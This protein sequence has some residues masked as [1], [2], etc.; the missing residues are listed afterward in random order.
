MRRSPKL[1][2][3]PYQL[4][5]IQPYNSVLMADCDDPDKIREQL[6]GI[7][8]GCPLSPY[9]FIIVQ[10]VLMY[11]VDER[12]S[13]E[14][15]IVEP[16]FIVTTDVLYADDTVLL[17]SCPLRLQV[18]LDLLVDERKKYGLELNWDKTYAM[19]VHCEG[20]I[21]DPSGAPIKVVTQT[22]YLGGLI[23]CTSVARPEVTR[24]R[25]ER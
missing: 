6:A 7:A 13:R 4:M 5:S 24:R 19:N 8:Q 14:A 1:Y 9:L 15:P 3:E 2:S 18:H 10:T 20:A 23:S 16:A 17:S 11:D 22:V 12:L 21:H 25:G